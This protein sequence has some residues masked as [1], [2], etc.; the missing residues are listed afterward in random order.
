M[1]VGGGINVDLERT[2]RRGRDKEIV[3]EV[4]IVG[5][6]DFLVHFLLRRQTSSRDWKMWN[7]LQQGRKVRS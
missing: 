7:M 6:E 4:E 1:I 2:G 3:V 5:L